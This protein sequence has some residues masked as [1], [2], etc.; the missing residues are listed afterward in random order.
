MIGQSYRTY[1]SEDKIL[2][3]FARE[4]FDRDEEDVGLADSSVVRHSNR[5]SLA[6]ISPF[7]GLDTPESD[8]AIVEGNLVYLGVSI[9]IV[10][11]IIL[12]GGLTSVQS[13]GLSYGSYGLSRGIF[14]WDCAIGR[15]GS[16]VCDGRSYCLAVHGRQ[17]RQRGVK[18]RKSGVAAR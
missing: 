17:L 11:D 8:L 18:P 12:K 2:R 9:G 16:Y 4:S 1:T 3:D 5:R 13:L 14:S 7:L 15:I 6:S 10:E